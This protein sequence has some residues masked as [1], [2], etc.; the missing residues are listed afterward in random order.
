MIKK[1]NSGERSQVSIHKIEKYLKGKSILSYN[2]SKQLLQS[3]QKKEEHYK[4]IWE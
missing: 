1:K 2:P 4:Y 3:K